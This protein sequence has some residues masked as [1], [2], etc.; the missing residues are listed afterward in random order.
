[1]ET[2]GVRRVWGFPTL[3]PSLAIPQSLS[4][5]PFLCVKPEFQPHLC[6]SSRGLG[7]SPLPQPRAS[8]YPGQMGAGTRAAGPRVLGVTAL[9]PLQGAAVSAS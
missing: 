6:P 4:P 2:L 5:P 3:A 1:M 8:V 9:P 7:V